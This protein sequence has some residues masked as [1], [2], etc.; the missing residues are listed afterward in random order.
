METAPDKVA[1]KKA[2]KAGTDIPG[3]HLET[4]QNIQIK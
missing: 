2:I 3:A 4:K 1:I